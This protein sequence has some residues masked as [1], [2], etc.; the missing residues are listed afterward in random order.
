MV[1]FNKNHFHDDGTCAHCR[2]KVELSRCYSAVVEDI[3]GRHF[4]SGHKA[5]TMIFMN[6]NKENFNEGIFELDKLIRE[7]SPNKLMVR[8]LERLDI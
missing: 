2:E 4:Y 1:N 5:C 7:K 3:S 8:T 6:R